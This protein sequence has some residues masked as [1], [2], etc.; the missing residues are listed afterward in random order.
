MSDDGP[1]AARLNEPVIDLFMLAD[2]AE[3]VNGKLY[4]MG[5]LWSRLFVQDFGRAT[6][7][8]FALAII[9]SPDLAGQEYTIQVV[10]EDAETHQSIGVNLQASF[11]V[12]GESSGPDREA[13]R[14]LLA[15]PAVP[16]K[17]PQAGRYEAVARILDGQERRAA[18]VA[19]ASPV[20]SA[21]T[22]PME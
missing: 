4:L 15:V 17:F 9:V 16:V 2:R 12:T 8:S 13:Q 19:I 22:T 7:I 6:P 10:V 1:I 18:F 11:T 14:V 21:E 3:V 5:G 20:P